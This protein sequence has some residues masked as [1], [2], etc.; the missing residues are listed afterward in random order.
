[1]SKITIFTCDNYDLDTVTLEKPIKK[2]DVYESKLSFV[3]QTPVVS[4][5]K[6]NDKRL[7]LNLTE[8]MEDLISAF[9]NK[10][11]SLLVSES[12]TLFENTL[13]MDDAEDIYKSSIRLLNKTPV[14]NV[15][16]GAKLNIY[17]KSKDALTIGNLSENDTVICL[18]KCKKIQFYKN[19]CQP[20]WE[21]SQIKLKEPKINKKTYLIMDDEND[22]YVENSDN[23][24]E[25][26]S[27]KI[28][29]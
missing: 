27:L 10:L 17:N 19:H 2:E 18:L 25:I 11:M 8:A 29:A 1:M 4:I 22:T 28:K 12:E 16:Y 24:S 21:V 3:I 23:E 15:Q 14:L 20:R 26:K 13:T 6:I 5:H 9:D 7:T